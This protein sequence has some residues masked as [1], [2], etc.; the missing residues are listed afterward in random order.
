MLVTL[1][2]I[3][4]IADERGIGVGAFNVPNL[5]AL[6]AVVEAA[7]EL[8]APVIIAH[9]EIHEKYVPIEVI[10]P[11]MIETAKNA[12]VPV[13]VHLDHGTSFN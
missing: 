6:T 2:E 4:K 8:N 3:C 5:E 9:V 7:E 11:I 10:G 13:C 1:K 12:S